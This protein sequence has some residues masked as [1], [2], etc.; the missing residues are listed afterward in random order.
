MHKLKDRWEITKN[1]QLIYIFLGIVGLI[2]CG[3]FIAARLIPA[4]F[5]DVSY[6]YLVVAIVTIINAFIFYKLAMW[7]FVK[8]RPRWDVKYR[9]ELIAIFVVFAITGSTSARLSGPV[10]EWI[11]LDRETTNVWIFWPI[12]L[13][14]I[15]PFYQVLLVLMGWLLG[16]F[17]FFWAFEKK[18]LG[19]FGIRMGNDSDN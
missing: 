19:R 16:Q 4:S 7:L 11:G 8:L 5:E 10:L 15:F 13:L 14:I 18:M 3:Y 6:E 12:R 17:E 2:A 9:W 1:W